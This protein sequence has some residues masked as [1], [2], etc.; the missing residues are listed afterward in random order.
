[1]SAHSKAV[2]GASVKHRLAAWV[3]GLGVAATVLGFATNLVGLQK[4]L[5]KIPGVHAVCASWGLGGVP[6]KAEATL[7]TQRVAGDCEVLR[8]YLAKFPKGAYAEEAGRRLQAAETV[9]DVLWTPEVQRPLLTVRSTLEPLAN[10]QAARADALTR[11]ETEAARACEGF[12][13]SEFRLL[14][15]T[16]EAQ[17]WRCF[18]R[19][20]GSVCGFDGQAICH[21]EARPSTQHQVCR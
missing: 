18:R 13:T 7:W 21:V 1:M 5:C 4:P 12:K 9:E 14:S 2:S 16:V 19:G 8:T 10:E 6:T 17:S 3:S 20:S 15:V 11:G